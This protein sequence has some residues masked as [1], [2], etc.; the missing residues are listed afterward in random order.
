VP[1]PLPLV[2]LIQ[3]SKHQYPGWGGGGGEGEGEECTVIL[4]DQKHTQRGEVQT[5]DT[6]GIEEDRPRR[7]RALTAIVLTAGLFPLSLPPPP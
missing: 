5:P 7:W 6:I 3:K 1:T 2:E 4:G